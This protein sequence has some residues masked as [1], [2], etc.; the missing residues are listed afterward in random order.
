MCKEQL[1]LC[2]KNNYFYQIIIYVRII[3]IKYIFKMLAF[4]HGEF[5]GET[6]DHAFIN[7]IYLYSSKSLL[8]NLY[9]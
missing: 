1:F 7:E 5:L 6:R 3:L 4:L 9:V 8:I 2:V